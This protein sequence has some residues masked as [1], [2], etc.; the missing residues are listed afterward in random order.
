LAENSQL[1]KCEEAVGTTLEKIE[2]IFGWLDLDK[3]EMLDKLNVL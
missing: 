1:R 2:E 3:D